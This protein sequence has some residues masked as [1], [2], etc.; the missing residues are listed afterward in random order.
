MYKR[1]LLNAKWTSFFF[2]SGFLDVLNSSNLIYMKYF[3][4][5]MYTIIHSK[6]ISDNKVH[7]S[8]LPNLSLS[9]FG[10]A[11]FWSFS[12]MVLTE[13]QTFY[14][15]RQDFMQSVQSKRLNRWISFISEC[16]SN[17]YQMLTLFTI[18]SVNDCIKSP[19]LS[20]TRHTALRH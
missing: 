17:C 10:Q 11:C 1:N 8:G 7:W 2:K 14:V 16:F 12:P 5:T 20:P 19:P 4:F 13:F 9:L 15:C 3:L 18:F 6:N